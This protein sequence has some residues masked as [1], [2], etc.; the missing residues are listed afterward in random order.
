MA[1][2]IRDKI[3]AAVAKPPRQ[4][5]ELP[6]WDFEVYARKLGADEQ[7]GLEPMLKEFDSASLDD[8][9]TTLARLCV[10]VLVDGDGERVFTDGD[11]DVALMRHNPFEVLRGIWQQAAEF[12]HMTAD[13]QKELA[14]SFDGPQGSDSPTA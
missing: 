3:V 4:K 12:N 1:N 11:G 6:E 14:A 7:V 2:A 8:K 9:L 5:I 10:L 13:K